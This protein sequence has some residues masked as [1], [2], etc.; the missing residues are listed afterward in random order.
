MSEKTGCLLLSD[1]VEIGIA[2]GNYDDKTCLACPH[3]ATCQAL[4]NQGEGNDTRRDSH[5]TP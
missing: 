4:N 5:R 3:H 2:A 1:A